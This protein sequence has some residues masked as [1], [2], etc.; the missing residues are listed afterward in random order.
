MAAGD[1]TQGRRREDT[2][3]FDLPDDLQPGDY[4]RCLR[5]DE[6]VPYHADDALGERG[7]AVDRGNLTGGVWGIMAPN[8]AIGCLTLHTVREEDDRTISVRPGDGSSNS[9]LVTE[10]RWDEET[11]AKVSLT[12]HGYIERG[13]WREV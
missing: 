6:P 8:G 3:Y 10:E 13:V 2:R 12:W 5:R 4:W 7:P 1:T 11:E 9:I